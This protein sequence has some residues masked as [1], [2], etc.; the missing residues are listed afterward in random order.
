MSPEVR[1][2]RCSEAEVREAWAYKT[3]GAWRDVAKRRL[4]S[5]LI[6]WCLLALVLLAEAWTWAQSATGATQ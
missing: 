3:A 1:C 5:A 2:P 6:G 4:R